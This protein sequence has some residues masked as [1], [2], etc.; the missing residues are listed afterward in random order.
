MHIAMPVYPFNTYRH[1][2]KIQ[3]QMNKNETE[4]RA[5]NTVYIRFYIIIAVLS[6]HISTHNLWFVRCIVSYLSCIQPAD[7]PNHMPYVRTHH[8]RTH[9]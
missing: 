1:N 2:R 8:A 3:Q 6:L 4:I 7:T 5:A 9:I